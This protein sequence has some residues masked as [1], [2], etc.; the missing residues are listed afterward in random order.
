MVLDVY[1][2]DAPQRMRLPV[3][4]LLAGRDRIIDN[5]RTRAFVARFAGPKEIIEYPEAYCLG[6]EPL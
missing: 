2:R 1:L 6:R 5:L 3:L 4:T